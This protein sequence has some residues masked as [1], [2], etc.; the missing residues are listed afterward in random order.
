M[1]EISQGRVIVLCCL[2][3]FINVIKC[4]KRLLFIT[5][6][7]LVVVTCNYVI[8]CHATEQ[9]TAQS[10]QVLTTKE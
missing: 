9:H 8:I 2:E 5:I 10:A 4:Q 1:T 3:E 7:D 6:T